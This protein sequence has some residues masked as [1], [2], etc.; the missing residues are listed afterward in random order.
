VVGMPPDSVFVTSIKSGDTVPRYEPMRT[1]VLEAA[2]RLLRT[3]PEVGAIVLECAN[4][5]PFS[6]D[7]AERF[8]VPVFDGVTLINWFHAGLR[9]RRYRPA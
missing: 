7:I 1:E 6:A 5:T 8:G 4:M 3:Y 2:E 9:P